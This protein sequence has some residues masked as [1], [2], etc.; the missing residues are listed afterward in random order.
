MTRLQNR[1]HN[2]RPAGRRGLAAVAA[3]LLLISTACGSSA[4]NAE[5]DGQTRQFE[6]PSGTVE[7]PASPESVVALDQYSLFGLLDVGY[8]PKAAAGGLDENFAILPEYAAQYE[9]MPKVGDP[10]DIDIEQVG[11][12]GPDLVLGNKFLSLDKHKIEDYQKVAPTAILGGGPGDPAVAW[13][14]WVIQAADAVGKRP[15]AEALKKQYED[16]AAAIKE[17]YADKLGALKFA[18]INGGGGKWF[19]NL[20]ESWGG[21][22]LKDLGVQFARAGIT[23]PKNNTPEFSIENLDKLD[24]ADVILYEADYE[25]KAGADTQEIIDQPAYQNLRAVKAG[26]SL[27][28]GNFYALHYKA[29]MKFQDEIEEILKTS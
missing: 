1:V 8:T 27:P 19:L 17:Q 20:D 28:T 3:G 14:V 24:E 13:P 29:A 25:G 2:G 11:A 12:Q 9:Q 22:I 4:E 26:K 6:T 18:L 21:T 15:E 16:R 5:V 7:I 10:L 23:D